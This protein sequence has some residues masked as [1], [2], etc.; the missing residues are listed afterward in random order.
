MTEETFNLVV[1][2]AIARSN[3]LLERKGGEYT[4]SNDRLINF[5]QSGAMECVPP[6]QS[7][8]SMMDK[9]VASMAIM[10]KNPT[11]YTRKEWNQRL[12]DIRN[13]TLLCDGLLIDLGIE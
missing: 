5:K 11:A 10:V 8:M 13:Y 7:L 12:D 6:T 3:K 4:S 2:K 1:E 9:H